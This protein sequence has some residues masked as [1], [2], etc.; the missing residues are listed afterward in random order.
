M[1]RRRMLPRAGDR[2]ARMAFA[3]TALAAALGLVSSLVALG[4]SAY[5][6]GVDPGL[7]LAVLCRVVSFSFGRSMGLVRARMML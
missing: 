7:W 5:Q 3:A 4:A 1:K 6:G 2:A